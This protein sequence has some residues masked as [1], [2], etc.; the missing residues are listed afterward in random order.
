MA[1]AGT[2]TVLA[3]GK[4]KQ[5]VRSAELV[6][7]IK[8]QQ[9]FVDDA[10]GFDAAG[11]RL[12]YVNADVGS[13][14]DVVVIDL[15]QHTELFRT[16][17][18]NFTV[19]PT[20]V[21]FALDGEHFVVW[22]NNA[23][24]RT[25][26]AALMNRKGA[27]L[28]TFG[29]AKHLVRTSYEGQQAIVVH[30]VE[31]ITTRKRKE[32][33]AVTRHKISVRSLEG[34]LLGKETTLDL[35][36][37]N[38]NAALDF[39]LKY[40]AHDF[41][42]AV[43]VKG[44]VW[45]RKEDQRSPDTEGWYVMPTRTFSKRVPIT[46]VVAQTSRFD[47]LAKQGTRKRDLVVRNDLSGIDFIQDGAIKPLSI[48]APFYHYDPKSLVVQE[49]QTGSIFFSLTV[50]PVHPDAAAKRRAVKPW[51]DLYEYAPGTKH[52]KRRAR[53]LGSGKRKHSWRANGSSWIL[54]PRHIGFERGGTKLLIYGLK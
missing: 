36:A 42:V 20:K 30:E 27:V 12:L 16:S 23:E 17:L 34:K 24:E 37:Q 6:H 21:E 31:R 14:A 29:P 44:G 8:P 38:K 19:K 1:T 39:E 25:T 28:R 54:V 41:T 45:D 9:G 48:K 53:F 40:W 50:D 3:K 13:S 4:Q 49:T 5:E 43:G 51:V 7:T 18:A 52:P 47:R 2:S 46:D 11:S 35:D 32:P 33:T 15:T 10:F 26:T 22:S